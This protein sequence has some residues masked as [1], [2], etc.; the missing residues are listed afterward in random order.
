MMTIMV[1]ENL[2]LIKYLRLN[3][4]SSEIEDYVKSFYQAIFG[5]SH[6]NMTETEALSFLE[7]EKDL[8]SN[9]RE[10]PFVEPIGPRFSRVYLAKV[11]AS[12]MSPMTFVRLF[13]L[14][15]KAPKGSRGDFLIALQDLGAAIKPCALP[16]NKQDYQEFLDKYEEAGY[17]ALHHSDTYHKLYEPHYLLLAHN[18][19]V[20]LPYFVEIDNL[21]L[22]HEDVASYIKTLPYQIASPIF[23]LWH[24]VYPEMKRPALV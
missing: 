6:L 16:F 13:L 23:D 4:P 22:N 17:P 18:L 8:L 24:D 9:L 14:S 12:N 5:P 2:E 15:N 1:N 7:E 21:V 10:D 20:L 11:I 19:A 3:Y